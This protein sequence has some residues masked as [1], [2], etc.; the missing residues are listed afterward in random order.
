[1][2]KSELSSKLLE[3]RLQKLQKAPNTVCLGLDLG[4]KQA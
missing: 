2:K 3:I 1:L 4:P